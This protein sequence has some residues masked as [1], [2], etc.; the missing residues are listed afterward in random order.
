MTLDAQD[1]QQA[2]EYLDKTE[3]G[4]RDAVQ[5]MSEAQW[6]FKPAP[7][8]WCAA[9]VLEHLAIVAGSAEQQVKN[10][11]DAPG[12]P[13][14]RDAKAI[15]ARILAA[16]PDRS[17]K[18]RAPDAIL[19][20]GRWSPLESQEELF[21]HCHNLRSQLEST[22]RLRGHVIPDVFLGPLDGYQWILLVAA[23]NARHTKQILELKGD[24]NFPAA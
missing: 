16:V 2:R 4:L 10:M 17:A 9:E 22:D 14:D 7:S 20:T 11:A 1:A 15:D 24:P 21:A 23:H 3:A 13:A 6:K 5:G 8:R 19:P 18:L 12:P